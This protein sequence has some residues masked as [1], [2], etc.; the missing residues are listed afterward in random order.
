M[1]NRDPVYRS[2]LR[3]TTKIQDIDSSLQAGRR[4]QNTKSHRRIQLL[5]FKYSIPLLEFLTIRTRK[6]ETILIRSKF[7]AHVKIIFYLHY[8]RTIS[9]L[10]KE[11]ET[12]L[13]ID[14]KYFQESSRINS[15]FLRCDFHLIIYT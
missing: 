11:E 15:E 1:R 12:R 3:L 4:N 5:L 8:P 13:L 7:I 9:I 2:L 10:E 6:E 14:L